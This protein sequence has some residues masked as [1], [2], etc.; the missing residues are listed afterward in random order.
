MAKILIIDDNEKNIELFKDFVEGWG[1][2]TILAYQGREAI[3]I[4][5]KEKPDAIILDVM[6]PGMSGYEVCSELKDNP[7]TRLIPIVMVTAL[8]DMENRAHG[9]NLGT[10]NFLIKPVN[11]KELR[12]IL[13]SLL[14]KKKWLE[15]MENKVDVLKSFIAAVNILAPECHIDTK[16]GKYA[17]YNRLLRYLHVPEEVKEH[18]LTTAVM[19][20]L[21]EAIKGIRKDENDIFQII[22]D[23]KLSEITVPL[24]KYVEQYS[25]EVGDEIKEKINSLK[26]QQEADILV[27]VE[28]FAILAREEKEN[29]DIAFKRLKAVAREHSYSKEVIAG[30]EQ[31][32]TDAH[33]VESLK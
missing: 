13:G 12:A 15:A 19:C 7:V 31:T 24:M 23:L 11:Y 3:E 27:V 22:A 6:L 16:T 28:K 29:L 33:F 25:T 2:S 18:I 21:E 8:P 5:Q 10:D 4:A 32:I 20:D 9:F 17:Y 30:L 1:Y 14:R 26:L